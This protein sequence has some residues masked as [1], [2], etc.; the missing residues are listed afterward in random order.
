MLYRSSTDGTKVLLATLDM[1][2]GAGPGPRALHGPVLLAIMVAAIGG[3]IVLLNWLISKAKG[4]ATVAPPH[5][6]QV[7]SRPKFSHQQ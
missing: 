1:Q 3:G 6:P 4:G 5:T 7:C 2:P